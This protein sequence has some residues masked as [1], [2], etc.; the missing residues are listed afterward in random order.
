MP[1][2]LRLKRAEPYNQALASAGMGD[3]ERTLQALERMAVL[4]PV[5]LGRDLTYPEFALVRGDPRLKALRKKVG[6]PD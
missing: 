2:R 5:R 3:K 4:G 6:L 1:R